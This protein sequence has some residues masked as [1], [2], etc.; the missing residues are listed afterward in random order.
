MDAGRRDPTV[1]APKGPRDEDRTC[2]GKTGHL[3]WRMP[4][5]RPILLIT[6]SAGHVGRL[7]LP[8]LREH[9]R[10]R[11]VDLVN[12]EPVGDDEVVRADVADTDRMVEASHGVRAVVHLAGRPKEADFSSLLPDNIVGTWSIFEAAARAG[13][14]CVVFASTIQTVTAVPNRR[15]RTSTTP[16]PTTVYA[17]TK[18]FGEALARYF[19][20]HRQLR[21]ACLRLGWVVPHDTA[22]ARTEPLLARTWIGPEDLSA[23]IRGAIE[24]SV[25]F[26]TVFAVSPPATVFFDVSNPYGW[27]P[28]QSLSYASWKR[29]VLTRLAGQMVRLRRG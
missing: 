1:P 10:L 6:G 25:P 29:L 7:I 18:L 27:Y 20:D 8:S 28:V 26:A 5:D 3:K 17:A 2:R 22:L 16:R 11:L 23:L 12:Q 9:Y 15:M 14:D 19:A 4:A 24:S 21:T 13:V